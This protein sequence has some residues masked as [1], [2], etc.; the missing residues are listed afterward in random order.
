MIQD[1]EHKLGYTELVL[2]NEIIEHLS[3]EGLSKIESEFDEFIRIIL[4]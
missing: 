2:I 4:I 3:V 1:P